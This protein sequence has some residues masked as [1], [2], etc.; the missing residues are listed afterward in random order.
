MCGESDHHTLLHEYPEPGKALVS[1]C[2]DTF[3]IDD[4]YKR[5]LEQLHT[6]QCTLLQSVIRVKN[7]STGAL[8]AVC[9]LID[10]GC[11]HTQGDL[12]IA[13][14][15]GVVGKQ[16]ECH[17]NGAGGMVF[18]C[19]GILAEVQFSDLGGSFSVSL[20][21]KFVKKPAGDIPFVNWK[22]YQNRFDFLRDIDLP[23]PVFHQ[24]LPQIPLIIGNDLA[25]LLKNRPG[26]Q[27][28][29]ALAPLSPLAQ[30]TAL[31]WAVCGYTSPDPPTTGDILRGKALVVES[32]IVL[33]RSDPTPF[34]V[35][36][37]SSIFLSPPPLDKHCR[38]TSSSILGDHLSLEGASQTSPLSK[39]GNHGNE[40]DSETDCLDAPLGTPML[41]TEDQSE[42]VLDTCISLLATSRGEASEWAGVAFDLRRAFDVDHFSG[43]SQSEFGDELRAKQLFKDGFVEGPS[44]VCSVPVMWKEN[45]PDLPANF[46]LASKKYEQ[47]E[48]RM[49]KN[50]AKTNSK[51]FFDE[52]FAALKQNGYIHALD[53]SDPDTLDGFFLESFCVFNPRKTTSALRL[54]FNARALFPHK[55]RLKSL[56]SCILDCPNNM[57]PLINVLLRMS[58]HAVL[59][60]GDVEHFFLRVK[61]PKCDQRYL[62]ILWRDELDPETPLKVYAFDAH[63]LGKKCS[64]FICIEVA[65]HQARRYQAE[66]P[67]ASKA[68]TE[69]M[70][71]DDLAT[72]VETPEKALKLKAEATALFG[73]HCN[74]RIRKWVVSSK[75]VREKIPEDEL[76]PSI[77]IE[78]VDCKEN[79]LVR[80]L[81]LILIAESDAFTY[82]YDLPVPEV[83]TR[84]SIL[85]T[86]SK[87]FDPRGWISPFHVSGRV[88]FQLECLNQP[89]SKLVWDEPIDGPGLKDIQEWIENC[90]DLSLVRIPRCQARHK[91]EDQSFT[92]D[93]PYFKHLEDCENP[94][95]CHCFWINTASSWKSH[96]GLTEVIQT[97]SDSKSSTHGN[98]CKMEDGDFIAEV[99]PDILSRL[100]DSTDGG[101]VADTDDHSKD[102]EKLD[103]SILLGSSAFGLNDEIPLLFPAEDSEFPEDE[104]F[105]VLSQEYHCFSDAS[106]TAL[107]AVCYSLTHYLKGPPTVRQIFAKGRITPKGKGKIKTIPR[108]ELTAALLATEVAGKVSQSFDLPDVKSKF[109]Y[110]CDSQV[111]LYWIRSSRRKKTFVQNRV[112]RILDRTEAENWRFCDGI[113]NP[114]DVV[115]RGRVSVRELLDCSLWW[116]GPAFLYK[117]PE[118]WPKNPVT[119]TPDEEALKEMMAEPGHL[120]LL[121][122]GKEDWHFDPENSSSTHPGR[123]N[124]LIALVRF[125]QVMSSYKKCLQAHTARVRNSSS[126]REKDSIRTSFLKRCKE[127]RIKLQSRLE[128]QK[129]NDRLQSDF[130]RKLLSG[131]KPAWPVVSEDCGLSFEPR[132]SFQEVKHSLILEA[133]QDVYEADIKKLKSGSSVQA[134]SSLARLKPFLNPATGLLEVQGR[135]ASEDSDRFVVILPKAHPVTRL[136]VKDLHVNLLQHFGAVSTL[137]AETKKR[138]FIPQLKTLVIKLLDSCYSCRRRYPRMFKQQMSS[139]HPGKLPG[140]L[141]EGQSPFS[142]SGSVNCD[143]LGPVYT[144]QGRGKAREKRWI[145]LFVC[146]TTKAIHLQLVYSSMTC[147]IL[148]ALMTFFMRRGVPKLIISDGQTGLSA[149]DKE[150]KLIRTRI[151]ALKGRIDEKIHDYGGFAQFDWQFT[152]PHTPSANGQVERYVSTVKNAMTKMSEFNPKGCLTPPNT[153]ACL[154]DK[155]MEFLLVRIEFVLNSAPLVHSMNKDDDCDALTRNHFVVGSNNPIRCSVPVELLDTPSEFSFKWFLIEEALL[156]F[157]D[158]WHTEHLDSIKKLSKW[159]SGDVKLEPNDLVMVVDKDDVEMKK[160]IKWPVAKVLKV[161]RDV[162][163][164]IQTVTLKYRN[165]ETRRGIRHLAPLPGVDF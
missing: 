51:D 84:R 19:K 150:L 17:T 107:G 16:I 27:Q 61:A 67:L 25:C 113:L 134:T 108:L 149:A 5:D 86:L 160:R 100:T 144:S 158:R 23:D 29:G 83:W 49:L 96:P 77:V 159:T 55:G 105:Q 91:D 90:K 127:V 154:K 140:R 7:P 162:D 142:F 81:G 68:I 129:E 22:N 138:Y 145:F 135:F 65:Q 72:S 63:L 97:S 53:M 132:P 48:K 115:S 2:S 139:F 28:R 155:E 106:Q 111:A 126:E 121:A 38:R 18:K 41:D 151:E 66:F 36:A 117:P 101:F 70:L 152:A 9:C 37:N 45:E 47:H 85:G 4:A 20:P 60:A 88:L 54:V 92:V 30:E 161:H 165:R 42:E 141:G 31:G 104:R 123:F 62:K 128:Q 137:M 26:S 99:C 24:G 10:S 13:D 147:D 34:E 1:S 109:T 71:V 148:T 110:W 58:Q 136:V 82:S 94:E 35:D 39:F 78:G 114:A 12:G 79:H 56:N 146:A 44:G 130:Y 157:W 122:N 59:I 21:I 131:K 80:C 98:V 125:V 153:L 6:E 119:V 43:D 93:H 76:S 95:Y 64:P 52:K 11:S 116:H 87:I 50:N 89:E 74:M 103:D 133:Q 69:S 124:S 120:L 57:V 40:T 118:Y 156:S 33:S 46:T 75:E 102:V 163:G 112:V 32:N 8:L 164:K 73:N 143:F 15:L 3:F 14:L